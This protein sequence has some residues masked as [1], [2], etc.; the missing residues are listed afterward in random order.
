MDCQHHSYS[1]IQQTKIRIEDE[2]QETCSRT[3]VQIDD[4]LSLLSEAIQDY[5]MNL[6]WPLD[7]TSGAM[8]HLVLP[9]IFFVPSLRGL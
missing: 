3:N 2:E 8:L 9:T 6:S 5:C 7:L 1:M 4:E